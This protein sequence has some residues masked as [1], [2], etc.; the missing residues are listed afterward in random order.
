METPVLGERFGTLVGG[1]TVE[2]QHAVQVV[3]FVLKETREQFVGLESDLFTREVDAA[4]QHFFRADHLDVKTRNGQTALFVHPLTRGLDDFGVDE[5]VGTVTNVVDEELFLNADLGC[6]ETNTGCVVH[7]VEHLVGEP[8]EFV[9]DFL[10]LERR[11][12]QHGITVC[13]NFVG[14]GARLSLMPDPIPSHYFDVDDAELERLGS[15]P[16]D[17]T[18]TTHGTTIT[19]TSD[20]GVFSYRRLDRGTSVLFDL[21]PTPPP[22]GTFLDL[23]CGWGAIALTL[24]SLSPASKV[25]AV[26]VNPRAT[27]LA[28]RNAARLGLDN[29]RVSQ[30]DDVHP[31]ITFDLIWSN[32]P[33]RVGKDALHGILDTWLNRLAVN[34]EAYLVVQKNLGS[35]SL[36]DWLR[37]KGFAV[38][39][40]G[41]RKGFRVL[42]VVRAQ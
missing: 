11:R 32:P 41:S 3:E 33:I 42:R 30:P 38:E 22:S 4:H 2:H 8:N 26:D 6:G 21:V 18:W 9:V 40:I 24:A 7:D 25:F 20:R 10:N 31:G 35:D 27:H 13:A 34:G 1:H 39:R 17:V 5:D 28:E 14:H 15:L 23:G 19:A 16:R 12:L 36:A 29:L 37:R